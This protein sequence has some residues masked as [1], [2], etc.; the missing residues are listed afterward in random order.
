MKSLVVTPSKLKLVISRDFYSRLEL[1]SREENLSNWKRRVHSCSSHLSK[2]I[3]SKTE[4]FCG[5]VVNAQGSPSNTWHEGAACIY[6]FWVDFWENLTRRNPPLNSRTEA[7]LRHVAPAGQEADLVFPSGVELQASAQRGAGSAGP[8]NWTAAEVKH[9]PFSCFDTM[10]QLF[11]Q[12]AE[13]ENVPEQFRQGRMV[14]IPK[15]NKVHNFAIRA[16]DAR[17]ICVMSVF[18]RIWTSA[19]CR[20]THMKRWLKRSLLPEVGAISGEDIYENLIQIF[21]DFDRNGYILT[22]DYGKAFDSIDT[23]LSCQLL[24]RHGWPASIVKFLGSVWGNQRRFIQWDHHTH[25]QP[26]DASCVQPQGDPLGPLVMSLWVMAGVMAVQNTT[27]VREFSTKV[28]IDDRTVTGRSAPDLFQVY[29][30]WQSWSQSVGLVESVSKTRVAAARPS[31]AAVAGQFFAEG[32]VHPAVK[33]LGAVSACARRALHADELRRLADAKRVIRLIGCCRFLLGNHLRCVRQFAISK[34]NFGWVSRSPNWG[35]SHSLFTAT[36]V[37]ACRVR[38]SSPWLR[39]LFLGGNLH[40]DVVWV[41][42]LVAAVLRFRLR[43]GALPSWVGKR[44]SCAACLRRWMS[45]KGF[46]ERRPWV[47]FHGV[48]S[49]SS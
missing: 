39:A 49:R 32:V 44:G 27:Q 16:E 22:L 43:S 45:D 3:K 42:R 47:W 23:R 20:S 26:L 31:N 41:T 34:A 21:D 4:C 9:L 28:Y 17:P 5:S 12:F 48:C 2:W 6:D 18:W 14:C 40:L 35:V 30:A 46:V 38:Y 25:N 1:K 37:A 7:L 29:T 19:L 24:L 15:G 36:F 13:Q 11:R 8:D 10:S 33:V